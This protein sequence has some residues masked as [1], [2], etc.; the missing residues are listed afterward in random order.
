MNIRE[1]FIESQGHQLA[2]LAVNEHLASD[3]KPAIVFIHGVLVSVN[4]WRDAVPPD[5]R[6]DRAWYA[7]SLPAHHPSTVPEDFAPEHVTESWFFEVM[8]GALKALLGER[9][10]IVVGHS[11]GGFCALNLAI[12]HSTSVA[13]IVSIAGF[14]QGQWGGSEGALLKLAGLGKWAKGLFIA[15]LLVACKSA[16]IQRFFASRLAHDPRAYRANPLSRRMVENTGANVRAQNL[17]ALFTLFNGI[18]RLEIA[19]TLH[20]I[21]V[22]CFLFAGT[23]DPV[24]P[25]HQSLLLAGNIEHAKT[26]VFRHVG[27]MPFMEDTQHCFDA[28]DQAVR[29]IEAHTLSPNQQSIKQVQA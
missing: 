5:F 7:L 18:S 11:T 24:V 14:H 3:D 1:G 26:V 16:Y 15:N 25:A 13:G 8:D 27:H 20:R 9:K 6:E 22:P 28:L 10:A 23:H 17:S 19:D 29:D 2:Y 21:E 12:H 4:F